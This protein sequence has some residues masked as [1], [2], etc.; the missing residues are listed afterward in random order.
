MD[1]K[2]K[3]KHIRTKAYIACIYYEVLLNQSIDELK[4]ADARWATPRVT[5]MREASEKHGKNK[6]K[7]C[8]KE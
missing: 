7:L 4:G 5:R 8:T 1:E 3:V 2:P 6:G